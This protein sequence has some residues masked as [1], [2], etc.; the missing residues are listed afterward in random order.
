MSRWGTIFLL[1]L[2]CGVAAFL[3][4]FEPNLR[5]SRG[6]DS[7]RPNLIALDPLQ[8]RG[9]RI[10]SGSNSI[11]L[12]KRPDGWFLGPEHEDRADPQRIADILTAASEMKIYDIIPAAEVRSEKDLKAFG[13]ADPRN[14]LEIIGPTS[15]VIHFGREAIGED[16]VYVRL[17]GDQT[18]YVV[19]NPLEDATFLNR[20]SFR[21]RRLTHFDASSIDRFIIRRPNGELEIERTPKG[22]ELKRPLRALANAEKVTAL[23]TALL[24]AP[25]QRFSED[26]ADVPQGMN[27]TA[28]TEIL[29]FPD[30]RD[31]SESIFVTEESPVE[32]QPETRVFYP[33]RGSSFVVDPAY[34]RLVAIHP[35][36]LRDRRLLPLN[37]DTVDVLRVERAGDTLATWRRVGEGWSRDSDETIVSAPEVTKQVYGIT[38]S[39]VSTYTAATPT[40]L[41]QA[42]LGANATIIHFDA[43]ISENTPEAAA[44]KQSV[45][46]LKIGELD[47]TSAQIQVNDSPEVC[48]VPSQAVRQFLDFA[49][50]PALETPPPGPI[51]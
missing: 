23:L 48:R 25:I 38:N 19:A 6:A 18:V 12:T 21:D 47:S 39:T 41:D 8:V 20:Q 51:P 16:R 37:L 42:G 49:L 27:N 50:E 29:F 1:L 28:T 35:E 40:A 13:L 31:T 46:R 15:T 5:S 36:E 26:S 24:G 10:T 4:I 17:E 9:L 2:A 30:T 7:S 43:T 44:G 11:E 3:F 22:W 34:S 45:S 32:G 33:T 14:K